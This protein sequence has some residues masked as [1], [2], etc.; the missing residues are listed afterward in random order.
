MLECPF[1]VQNGKVKI[2]KENQIA[3]LIAALGSDQQPLPGR[4]LII[5]KAHVES[6][7]DLPDG[8]QESVNCLLRDFFAEAEKIETDF[9]LSY[10]EGVRAGQ[11]VKHIHCWF[12]IRSGEEG[13][14][15]HSLGLSALI[16]RVNKVN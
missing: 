10:N 8:W 12:I 7:F 2:L 9:N 13:K 6:I 14:S 3:Y 4:Y 5:P 1:C 16:E 11:R 15:S